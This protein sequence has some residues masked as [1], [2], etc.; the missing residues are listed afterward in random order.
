M[1][2]YDF[3]DKGKFEVDASGNVYQ[4]D[5]S[6]NRNQLPGVTFNNGTV[7]Q[8]GQVLG[9]LNI[10]GNTVTYSTGNQTIQGS[11]LDRA[12][13][14]QTSSTSTSSSQTAQGPQRLD[15]GQVTA[16]NIP[17]DYGL[18]VNTGAYDFGDAGQYIVQPDSV[19]LQIGKDGTYNPIGRIDPYGNVWDADGNR[20][21]RLSRHPEQSWRYVFTDTQGRQVVGDT[22][23]Y[24]QSNIHYLPD[25]QVE[26]SYNGETVKY[27]PSTIDGPTNVLWGGMYDFGDAGRFMVDKGTGRIGTWVPDPNATFGRRYRALDMYVDNDGTVRDL[28]GN[29]VGRLEVTPGTG[30]RVRFI[31]NDGSVM[32]GEWGAPAFNAE[33]LVNRAR[34]RNVFDWATAHIQ[35]FA[36]GVGAGTSTGTGGSV[37]G[38][39]AGGGSVPAPRVAYSGQDTLPPIPQEHFT[40]GTYTPPPNSVLPPTINAPV[41]QSIPA[42]TSPYSF[43]V[44]QAIPASLVPDVP[45]DVFAEPYSIT[46]PQDQSLLSRAMDSYF[47]PIGSGQASAQS[48]TQSESGLLTRAQAA[49]R[50]SDAR[51]LPAPKPFAEGKAL[52]EARPLPEASQPGAAQRS[53]SGAVA[54]VHYPSSPEQ[55]R[56]YQ[57]FKDIVVS[58][59]MGQG[60]TKRLFNALSDFEPPSYWSKQDFEAFKALNKKIREQV[61]DQNDP[62]N[63]TLRLTGEE[64]LLLKDVEEQTHV[65][66]LPKLDKAPPSYLSQTIVRS[67]TYQPWEPRSGRLANHPAVQEYLRLLAT[68]RNQASAYVDRMLD[69]YHTQRPTPANRAVEAYFGLQRSYLDQQGGQ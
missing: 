38:S 14:V 56:A 47:T 45:A 51:P 43:S 23:E 58:K 19:V 63:W 37:G 1:A 42:G 22:F 39:F 12:S 67:S 25:H 33:A 29:P 40:D 24:T 61:Q 62:S 15:F 48:Q 21:G 36:P 55:E 34:N 60:S 50:S 52:P 32:E 41:T 20:L 4:L 18:N 16:P 27:K 68:D 9:S 35:R 8:N 46:A 30:H 10:S 44:P 65:N 11:L 69:Y 31:S 5:A 57:W 49:S 28:E 2:I 3:G 66:I 13:S 59:R 17:S 64:Y 53:S 54:N 7:Y 26:V 6:G